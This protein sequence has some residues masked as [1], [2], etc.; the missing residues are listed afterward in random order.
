MT[1]ERTAPAGASARIGP[2]Q[3]VGTATDAGGAAAAHTPRAARLRSLD[4]LRGVA[5]LIV[6]LHHSLLLIPELSAQYYT[7]D[8]VDTS[9]P[10]AWLLTYT[11]LHLI[12]QGQTA[13]YV[14]FV[15]S[16]I[17]LTLPVLTSKNFAWRAYYP[18]RLLRLYL[19]VWGAVVF[20]ALVIVAVPRVA[21]GM[22]K[23]ADARADTVTI[24]GIE[25]DA[26]LL[27]GAGVLASP[28]WS[29]QWE[30]LF[31]ILLPLF[32]VLAVTFR[33][34]LVVKVVLVLAV[35]A[36]AGALGN[37]WFF[38]LAMFMVGSLFATQ[39]DRLRVL[40]AWIDAHAHRRLLWSGVLVLG[41]LL[42]NSIWSLAI[43]HPPAWLAN[44][45]DVLPLMGAAVV[46]FAATCWGGL[47]RLLER[48][49][50]QWLGLMSFSLYLVHEPIVLASGYFFGPELLWVAIP[51]GIALSLVATWVF[52]RV[53]EHPSHL[54]AQGVKRWLTPK[55][56]EPDTKRAGQATS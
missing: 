14:F 3:H 5:A 19:P 39:L 48:P 20:A 7:H 44:A 35:V 26:S 33:R 38:Y 15:L 27:N 54:L 13:V 17:V 29:L 52:Y 22:S 31:S 32:V 23:W 16:G 50:V 45:E 40:G 25:K 28:L 53:V 24:H 2:R 46:I 34:F 1:A 51:V 12:W 37:N 11:P 49:M 41:L 9:G 47:A 43:A 8:A 18:Q 6:V 10:I 55:T 42:I 56:P 30:V 4:G 21:D 36:V